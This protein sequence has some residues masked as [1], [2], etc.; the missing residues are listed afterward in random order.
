[1]NLIVILN[2]RL[3]QSAV[4]YELLKKENRLSTAWTVFVICPLFFCLIE[5]PAHYEGI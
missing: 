5:V 3:S 4:F 2:D 1:M